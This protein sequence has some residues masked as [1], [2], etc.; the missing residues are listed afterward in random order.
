M[1]VTA[2]PMPSPL[3]LLAQAAERRFTFGRGVHATQPGASRPSGRSA[4]AAMQAAPD[5]TRGGAADCVPPMRHPS[6]PELRALLRHD[7]A[8]AAALAAAVAARAQYDARVAAALTQVWALGVVAVVF[9][10]PT[11]A[12]AEFYQRL[13]RSG[14]AA[15][16]AAIGPVASAAHGALVVGFHPTLPRATLDAAAR[17]VVR[18]L[19]RFGVAVEPERLQLGV[20]DCCDTWLPLDAAAAAAAV[21]AGGGVAARDDAAAVA[22]SAAAA[23]APCRT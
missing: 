20:G 16:A 2:P 21:D 19:R 11:E 9:D 22:A 13:G 17:V 10:V 4:I 12:D 8:D 7:G 23:A 15:D 14:D 5:A 6:A 18:L 3:A 1:V